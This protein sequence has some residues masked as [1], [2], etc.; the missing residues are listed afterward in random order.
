MLIHTLKPIR[1]YDK[2]SQELSKLLAYDLFLMIYKPLIDLLDQADSRENARP[3]VLI[4]AFNNR[5]IHY[6]GGFVYGKF[7]AS[8]SK[9]LVQLGGKFNNTKKAFKIDLGQ[10]PTEIRASIAKGAVVE[11]QAI[12]KMIKKAQELKSDNIVIPG[13]D[14]IS[15]GTIADLHKQFEKLTP[16]DLEIPVDMNETQEE[17][18]HTDYTTNVHLSI[19]NLSDEAIERLRYRVQD[20]VGQGTRADKLKNILFA[21]YGV[22]SNRAKFIARQETSL[23]V[24]KYRQ[25]RYEDAGVNQY[26]WS[27]SN[28][29][30]VREDHKDLNG[31]IFS[32]DQP[33]IT[34]KRTG[35]RNNPGEDFGCRCVALPV[36]K[37]AGVTSDRP[38]V[39]YEKAG[40]NLLETSEHRAI[41]NAKTIHV[42][43][44]PAEYFELVKEGFGYPTIQHLFATLIESK[45]EDIRRQMEHGVIVPGPVLEYKWTGNRIMFWQDGRHRVKAA[46]DF[47]LP[48]VD[49]SVIIPDDEIE[50]AFRLMPTWFID[51][52]KVWVSI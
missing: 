50:E 10:F 8:I 21:E 45:V 15:K 14:G 34:D 2:Y 9:A 44:K 13:V 1:D 23:F 51:K 12:D 28:D 49:C 42:D 22:I 46:L 5:V 17:K 48:T 39:K 3:S 24:A 31:R 41:Y 52:I 6:D 33:P 29:E 38:K 16:E 35:A 36:V 25:V 27:T 40:D 4:N 37:V 32:W 30:R 7:N 20:E 43:L 47:G 11:Q 18:I 26:Q 19:K